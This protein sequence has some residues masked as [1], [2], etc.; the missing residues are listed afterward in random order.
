MELDA[1][2]EVGVPYYCLELTQE[3]A[4]VVVISKV[5]WY[6]VDGQRVFEVHDENGQP[7]G[8]L[9]AYILFRV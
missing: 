2:N 5:E 4:K 7:T 1:L 3:Q 8:K 9:V 6:E